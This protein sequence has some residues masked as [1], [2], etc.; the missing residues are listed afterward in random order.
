MSSGYSMRSPVMVTYLIVFLLLFVDTTSI[1]LHVIPSPRFPCNE[2]SCVMI[3]ELAIRYSNTSEIYL[4]FFPGEHFLNISDFVTFEHIWHVHMIGSTN[5]THIICTAD[6]GFEFNFV[7]EILI[8]NIS[9]SHCGS[10]R[11][12]GA[13]ISINSVTNL[14]IDNI[15]IYNSSDVGIYIK[16]AY[17]QT[18]IQNSVISSSS[19]PNIM[20]TW[21]SK[22]SVVASL[23]FTMLVENTY[24]ANGGHNIVD[25]VEDISGGINIDIDRLIMEGNILLNNVTFFN[26]S[27]SVGGNLKINLSRRSNIT[28]SKCHL[29][30]MAIFNSTIN[31][32]HAIR[33]GGLAFTESSH[34][35][36]SDYNGT[37]L[38]ISDTVVVNNRATDSGGGMDFF[39]SETENTIHIFL[40]NLTIMSNSVLSIAKPGLNQQ[41][42]TGGGV[43]FHMISNGKAH[44]NTPAL[45]INKCDFENNSA[46]SG[47]GFHITIDVTVSHCFRRAGKMIVI[48]NSMLNN[49]YANYG[50]GGLFSLQGV[51]ISSNQ[52]IDPQ[53]FIASTTFNGNE[54]NMQAS[55]MLISSGFKRSF[56]CELY[57]MSFTN[58]NVKSFAMEHDYYGGLPSTLFLHSVNI[59][60][61]NSTFVH[62][63]GSGMGA[64]YSTIIV[65]GYLNFSNNTARIGA[66]I[67]LIASY[68][69]LIIAPSITFKHNHANE[70]GG[71]IYST[72]S[73]NTCFY[74][75]YVPH[76]TIIFN[77][78]N[79]SADLAGNILYEPT[80]S[81]CTVFNNSLSN[82]SSLF[83]N[84]SRS[85]VL[86]DP[87]Q[88]CICQADSTY[89]CE[90][91]STSFS[92][93]TGSS[94]HIDLAIVNKYNLPTPGFIIATTTTTGNGTKSFTTQDLQVRNGN[95]SKYD[96]SPVAGHQFYILNLSPIN[97]KRHI[98]NDYVFQ[99]IIL[100]ILPCPIGFIFSNNSKIC[101]CNPHI[102]ANS[103]LNCNASDFTIIRQ[104]KIWIGLDHS[105]NNIVY[106]S[107]PF[108]YC[109]Q[110]VV[111]LHNSSSSRSICASGRE[112]ILCGECRQNHSLTI[113]SEKCME[114][115]N[116][117]NISLI[118][119]FGA[120]GIFL[121]II[122]TSLG[123]TSVIN[124][125]IFYTAFLHLNRD[126]FF[127]LYSNANLLVVAIS[128]LNLDFG[129]NVCFYKGMTSQAKIWL[130]FLFPIYLFTIELLLILSSYRSSKLARISG[131]KNRLKIVSTIFLLG[132]MKI[133][134]VVV[135]ILSFGYIKTIDNN[136]TTIETVWLYDG[137]IVY[138]SSSHIPLFCIAILF[139]II[140]S[141]PYMNLLLFAQ[142]IQRLPFFPNYKLKVNSVYDAHS[143]L[144]KEK[145]RFWLGLLLL[146]YT[147][148][149]LLYYFTGG[150]RDI[151]LAALI[152][153]CSVLLIL[154][155][156]FGG[157]YKNRILNSLESLLLF[158]LLLLSVISANNSNNS[159]IYTI[160]TMTF[161]V[162]FFI[163]AYHI[164]KYVSHKKLSSGCTYCINLFS[165]KKWK[166]PN[167]TY[168]WSNNYTTTM[169][170]AISLE[171][172]QTEY[173]DVADVIQSS[174]QFESELIPPEWKPTIY[175]TPKFREDP[176]LLDDT[177]SSVTM[178]VSSVTR[179]V[180]SVTRN[181]KQS[182]MIQVQSSCLVVNRLE[183]EAILIPDENNKFLRSQRIFADDSGNRTCLIEYDNADAL[184]K[185]QVNHSDHSDNGVLKTDTTMHEVKSCKNLTH[186]EIVKD[187]SPSPKKESQ[188]PI[189]VQESS[190]STSN[191]QVNMHSSAKRRKKRK[192]CRRPK[193]GSMCHKCDPSLPLISKIERYRV[194][195]DGGT[196]S[197]KSHDIT[198]KVP[199]SAVKD[200]HTVMIEVGVL[201]HGPF[202]FPPN[203][204]PISPILWVCVR[205]KIFFQKSIDIT[206]PHFVNIL[207]HEAK[208]LGMKFMKASHHPRILPDGTREYVF[209]N[210][211]NDSAT[212]F[213]SKLG[214]LK[215]H[216]FCFLCISA[217]DS[218][219]LYQRSCYCLTRVDP[220]IRNQRQ[221]IYFIV[222]YLLKTCLQVS[223]QFLLLLVHFHSS[224]L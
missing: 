62:N 10:T 58:N 156:I 199:N 66:G 26:N 214:T 97:Y 98:P 74:R 50:A 212:S 184:R 183:D 80:P 107:C 210:V 135:T 85:S 13:T 37:I 134:R 83:L 180:S 137:N 95:C 36:A 125:V 138:F 103:L 195:S 162:V 127:P 192:S 42:S 194:S 133:F 59:S 131:A 203:T 11:R 57:N 136:M 186:S 111:V 143:G 39:L 154:N 182:D 207:P 81:N 202:I 72:S 168:P 82:N 169:E 146:S 61:S 114:C 109:T 5:S 171:S 106:S 206:L 150:D 43:N 120:L 161:I 116:D 65:P 113:G 102:K 220:I 159:A 34:N 115:S 15:T 167:N 211:G 64:S 188:G 32:G 152:I 38:R 198:L 130:Q 67:N 140:V 124:G 60:I 108:D 19:F 160:T 51:D 215:T 23:V 105:N 204:R 176:N 208:L 8:T 90:S 24:I 119:V 33:G 71:A 187:P 18:L 21:T 30:N 3:S 94:L 181:E 56:I 117:N 1:T 79:N 12:D 88:I 86:S 89:I 28:N 4:K 142:V 147:I 29:L 139:L 17:G 7:N 205:N 92:I 45:S 165:H 20:L 163:F 100:K 173:S 78:K 178:N 157:V 177:L 53:I 63:V 185:K 224:P 40:N 54:A 99:K 197:L 145:F 70:V 221:E 179:N 132:Y 46:F 217:N 209:N 93:I 216:H 123:L 55:G 141:F 166:R 44:M 222:S 172:L 193:F 27:G 47:A 31:N 16:E 75:S 170:H 164:F 110:G 84:G 2:L 52:C 35:C 77:F 96:Y 101:E 48:Q 155:I 112:G 174:N 223:I 213:T 153:T 128:W 49:N 126:S 122:V 14:L 104:S 129:F 87:Y 118:L 201:M 9:F 151:N 6:S 76:S 175:P 218:R 148:L 200:E 219:A 149:V 196:F 189:K 25:S 158:S 69:Q 91:K 22:S 68:L 144:F 190:T 191:K 121:V 41:L 73:A